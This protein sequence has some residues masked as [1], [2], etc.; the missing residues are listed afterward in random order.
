M[1]RIRFSVDGNTGLKTTKPMLA[2]KVMVKATVDDTNLT[3]IVINLSTKEL[4]TQGQSVS[5]A[6]LRKD[7]RD[8]LSKLGVKFNGEVRKRG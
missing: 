8:S 2:D 4:V 6:M 7:L 3:F 5:L 1:T